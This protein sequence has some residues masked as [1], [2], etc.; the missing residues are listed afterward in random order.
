VVGGSILAFAGSASAATTLDPVTLKGSIH[1]VEDAPSSATL[2]PHKPYIVRRALTNSETGE[3]LEFE[4]SLKMRSFAELQTR[5]AHRELISFQE[6]E[7][8]YNPTASDYDTVSHWLTSEG[9][10]IVR[11]DDNHLA[12]F[13]QGTVAQIQAAS[14][15]ASTVC[16]LIS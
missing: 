10:S 13:A 14:L 2:K 9:F 6:M 1:S 7:D 4:V 15:S 3:T 5:V 8:K 12:V 11:Q 16:N